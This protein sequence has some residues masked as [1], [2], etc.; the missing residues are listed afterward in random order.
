MRLMIRHCETD[1]DYWRIRQFLREVFLLN[2]RREASWQTARMDYW[3]WHGIENM[4]DGALAH[5]VFIWQAPDGRIVSVLNREAP[6]S[7]FLQVHPKLS[8]PGVEEEMVAVAERELAWPDKEGRSKVRIWAGHD[9]RVRQELLQR[10]GFIRTGSPE[11]QRRRVLDSPMPVV[12]TP[13]GYV[14]RPLGGD[15]EIPARSWASWRAFH[16]NE[17][18]AAYRG[19]DW[20][21]VI[22]RMPLYRRDLD[23][24]AVTAL[25]E[26]AAFCTVW[27][28]DVTRAGYFEP[29][30]RVDGHEARGLA[31]GVLLEA[32]R[33]L[34]QVG[35]T[36]A[37]IGG[38]T[39]AA[40]VLYASV[41]SLDCTKLEP[42]VKD[43]GFP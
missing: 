8:T 7:V 14:I 4:G 13:A 11:C 35:G 40:N 18:D 19:H 20:Y 16:P 25:G 26:V 12:A 9:N 15:D 36:L 17:P 30:G 41:T 28:D 32:M 43:V 31:R 3:R 42:W 21:R 2:D 29:V 6:G 39:F 34:Q 5:D 22:Q 1:D 27:Y 23:V 10:H 38:G 24:V 33:R 37:T